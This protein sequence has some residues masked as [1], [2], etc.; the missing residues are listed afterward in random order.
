MADA[1]FEDV[2]FECC[3]L[4]EVDLLGARFSGVDLRGS[5]LDGIRVS[6]DQLRGVIVTADQALYLARSLGLDIRD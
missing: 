4:R 5:E 1:T 6:A 2:R 3:D